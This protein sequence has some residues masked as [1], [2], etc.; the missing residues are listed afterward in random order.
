MKRRPFY[1]QRRVGTSLP[2]SV[3]NTKEE[4]DCR[5]RSVRGQLTGLRLRLT[6]PPHH[7]D[8]IQ[9]RIHQEL[10]SRF[11]KLLVHFENGNPSKKPTARCGGLMGAS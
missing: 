1:T 7:P 5:T 10:L 9:I 11:I 2:L 8:R 6:P 3:V 4:T